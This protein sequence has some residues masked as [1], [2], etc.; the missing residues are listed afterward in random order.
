MRTFQIRRFS[1]GICFCLYRGACYSPNRNHRSIHGMKIRTTY[2]AF[3]LLAAMAFAG[4]EIE[5]EHGPRPYIQGQPPSTSKSTPYLYGSA[6]VG[7][8]SQGPGGAADFDAGSAD[9]Q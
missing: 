8:Q 7:E 2:G 5:E 9:A 6:I 1:T 3:A 4:C